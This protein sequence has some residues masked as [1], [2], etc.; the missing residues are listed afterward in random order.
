M[1][2]FI[3]QALASELS[4]FLFHFYRPQRSCGEGRKCFY[5]SLSFCS[6]GGWGGGGGVCLSGCWD[7]TLPP[8]ADSPLKQTPLEQTPPPRSRHHPPEQMPP[9]AD[10]LGAD[11]PP[12]SRHP[13]E[14]D[15]P[16]SRHPPPEQ[17]PPGQT[18]PPPG[19]ADSGIR[20]MSGRYASYWNAFLL[21]MKIMY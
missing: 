1:I 16:Q 5:S 14:A 19:E 15:I 17:T 6:Q 18:P 9:R 3:Y 8:G 21:V 13:P 12:Q 20:S 7:T 2:F 10:P 4:D 11:T